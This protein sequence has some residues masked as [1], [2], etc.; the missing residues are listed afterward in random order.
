VLAAAVA[1]GSASAS[2]VQTVRLG[3]FVFVTGQTGSLPGKSNR[4]T[5][6]VVVEAQWNG[7][8]WH[9]VSLARTD[10]DGNYRFRIKPRMR[11]R[12]VLRVVPPDRQERL[13]VVRVL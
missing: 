10:G 13:L 3:G 4:S 6:R 11:G 5:G 8:D 9:V 12:L 1:A 7:G 2:T